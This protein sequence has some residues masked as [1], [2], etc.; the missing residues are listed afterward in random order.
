MREENE[1][2]PLFLFSELARDIGQKNAIMQLGDVY[3]I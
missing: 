2:R 1:A 3:L